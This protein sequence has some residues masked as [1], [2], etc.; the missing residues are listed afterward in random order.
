MRA[1]VL[2]APA[3]VRMEEITALTDA[4]IR[5]SASSVCGSNLW[6]YRGGESID[7]PTPWDTVRRCRPGGRP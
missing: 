3:D 5:L 2:H 7:G 6:P 4:I 1:A